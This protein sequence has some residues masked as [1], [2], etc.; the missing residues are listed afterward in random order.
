VNSFDPN[1][2]PFKDHGG[3]L[4]LY[5]AWEET[6]VPP[7]TTIDYYKS[8]LAAMGGESQTRDFFRLFMVPSMGMCPGFG[9]GNNGTFD[10]LDVV[11]K[12]RT[13]NVAPDTIINSHKVEG[14]VDRT[15]PACPYPQEAIYKGSG[16]PYDAAN[17]TCGV[18]K[19]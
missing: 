15:H 6:A 2:K 9:L 17:F 7:R 11:M 8:V 3:K 4:L 5:Q 10:A 18:P 19:N 16:D 13:T 12:W 14:V 1:L